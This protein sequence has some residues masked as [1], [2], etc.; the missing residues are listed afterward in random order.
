MEKHISE[1]LV[2]Y[3]IEQGYEKDSGGNYVKMVLANYNESGSFGGNRKSIINICPQ[4]RWVSKLDDW[5]SVIKDID[6]RLYSDVEKA[7][8]YLLSNKK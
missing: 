4:G 8:E 3:L 6:L 7:L 1:N 5:G 2:D